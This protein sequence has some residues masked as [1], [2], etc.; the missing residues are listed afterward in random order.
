MKRFLIAGLMS[1][2]VIACSGEASPPT[3]DV[4]VS[5][6]QLHVVVDLPAEDMEYHD[7]HNLSAPGVSGTPSSVTIE[8][9]GS[10]IEYGT[11]GNTYEI[12]YTVRYADGAIADYDISI[13]GSVYGDEEFTCTN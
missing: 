4:Y 11:T 6:N 7:T 3:C 13:K 12:S 5:G 8:A 10:S 1:M 2:V 9:G